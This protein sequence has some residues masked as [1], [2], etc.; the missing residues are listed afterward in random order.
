MGT[1]KRTVSLGLNRIPKEGVGWKGRSFRLE[2]DVDVVYYP[3]TNIRE[4]AI[5]VSFVTGLGSDDRPP[6]L[7]LL[8]CLPEKKK[9]WLPFDPRLHKGLLW[10]TCTFNPI[11]AIEAY[12]I[13]TLREIGRMNKKINTLSLWPTNNKEEMKFCISTL[14]FFHSIA[15]SFIET[16]NRDDNKANA[17]EKKG[18]K[19]CKKRIIMKTQEH[20]L[21]HGNDYMYY[22]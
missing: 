16:K 7:L 13:H 10:R 14:L 11:H 2:G 12:S 9:R 21:N 6:L 3:V 15:S 1:E 5:F 19:F 4:R 20:Q 22:I 8:L 17:R 18:K